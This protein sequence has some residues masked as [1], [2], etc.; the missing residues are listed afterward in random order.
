MKE[1]VFATNNKHKLEEISPMINTEFNLISLAEI[2]CTADIVENEDTLEG[3]AFLKARFININYG[4]DCFADDTGLEIDSL[5][6]KPGVY[7]ARYAGEPPDF[8]A[9]I[10]K[11]LLELKGEQNRKARFRTV[12][13]LIINDNEMMFEG[14]VEGRIIDN[15][16][17]AEGFGYDPIFIPE[18]YDQT[19][20][21]M[22]LAEK[23]KIS[24]RAKA[25]EKLIAFLSVNHQ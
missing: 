9:N 22:P 11:V 16:K 12:I 25:V 4:Y 10:N 7:S 18:G 21:E 14:I 5:G 13:A 2:G 17:G 15:K 19:F 3:N 1:L 20:A 8:E 23:N 24:H 6:G